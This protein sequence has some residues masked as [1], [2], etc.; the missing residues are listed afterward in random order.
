M[1]ERRCT[2]PLPRAKRTCTAGDTQHRMLLVR[3]ARIFT[4][5]VVFFGCFFRFGGHVLVQ[6]PLLLIEECLAI[7]ART[8]ILVLSQYAVVRMMMTSDGY[9]QILDIGRK[10][11]IVDSCSTSRFDQ[12]YVR[13]SIPVSPRRRLSHG[14]ARRCADERWTMARTVHHSLAS[15]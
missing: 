10:L 6:L 5:E 12:R 15:M 11:S 3:Y 8:D 14:D 13:D 2:G 9:G 7:D 4:V 1:N